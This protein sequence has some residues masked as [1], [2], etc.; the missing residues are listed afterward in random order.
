MEDYNTLALAYTNEHGEVVAWS[1]DTFGSP[2]KYPKTYKDNEHNRTM[3]TK[4]F[5]SKNEFLHK[6]TDLVGKH[7]SFAGALMES[8]A[9]CNE[10]FFTKNGVTETKLFRLDVLTDYK[11]GYP[12]WEEVVR[13]VDEKNYKELKV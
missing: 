2:S 3:L 5:E 13:A 11:D 8:S 4:K 7:N 6:V 9:K 1:S 12:K 10:E